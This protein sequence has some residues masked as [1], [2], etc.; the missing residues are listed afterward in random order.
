MKSAGARKLSV[1]GVDVDIAMKAQSTIQETND[2]DCYFFSQKSVLE[3]LIKYLLC[4]SCKKPSLDL[5]F[6]AESN[7]RVSTKG[8]TFVA[9]AEVVTPCT[10]LVIS[11]ELVTVVYPPSLFRVSY[12]R[13]FAYIST[14]FILVFYSYV[15]SSEI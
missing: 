11:L 15:D 10:Y 5:D 3:G 4:P 6:S 8:K 12:V 13:T 2:N 1:C 9:P 7:C 14:I